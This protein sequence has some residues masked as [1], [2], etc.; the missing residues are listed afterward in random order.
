MTSEQG[1]YR[2]VH[3]ADEDGILRA[4]TELVIDLNE[5]YTD[6]AFAG[7]PS[8]CDEH[9]GTCEALSRVFDWHG[10]MGQEE[11]NNYKYVFDMGKY[12]IRFAIPIFLPSLSE[13]GDY[14]RW[15]RMVWPIP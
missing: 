11:A 2:N 10:Q 8:Q 6:V 15:K 1:G 9:D 14:Y 5:R 3:W 7:H 12:F 13:K 4:S